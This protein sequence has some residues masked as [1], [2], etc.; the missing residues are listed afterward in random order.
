MK[1]IA[2]R[3]NPFFKT[4]RLWSGDAGARRDAGVALLEGIHLADA[5]L[6]SGGAPRHVVAGRSALDEA[7]V[8]ALLARMPVADRYTLDDALFDTLSQVAHGIALLLIVEPPRPVVPRRIE[9]TSVVL[10]R[11]QDPGNVGSILRSAAA[12][13]IGDVYLSRECAGAWSPK[14]LRA[15]MGG[16]FHLRLFEEC[17]P[18]ALLRDTAIPWLSTSPHATAS[19][20]ETDLTG[21]VVWAFGHEGQ[22]LDPALMHG[23]SAVRIPQPGHGESLNVAASAAICLFEQ[24]RQRGARASR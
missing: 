6:K 3:D 17:E 20:H 15:A 19:V 8:V 11:V 7:E 12:A 22:G 13:G 16:H 9:R 21:D 4:L 10:D 14:V 24:V 23:A 2:S 5:F 18:T 1:R